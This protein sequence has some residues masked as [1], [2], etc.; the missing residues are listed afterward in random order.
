MVNASKFIPPTPAD[1]V[2]SKQD[3]PDTSQT[4]QST[5][6]SVRQCSVNKT[7]GRIFTWSCSA[8]Q[9]NGSTIVIEHRFYG[10]SNPY[11]DLSVKSLKLHTIQQA[12]DDLEYFAKNVNLPM[13][14][15]DSVGPDK[16]P[17][18]LVGGS[19][20]GMCLYTLLK[21]PLT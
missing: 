5:A 13:P 12:I 6:S 7:S 10:L 2:L 15:G 17:W 3:I 1:E 18:I 16:A 9:Q 21:A 8:Q 4:E 20:S 14:G 19:Y 11:P